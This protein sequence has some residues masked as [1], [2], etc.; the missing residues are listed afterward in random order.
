MV[1]MLIRRVALSRLLILFVALA[2]AVASAQ[3]PQGR[4]AAPPAELFDVLEQ[5]ILD[6]Q[7]AQAAMRAR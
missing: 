4:A 7:A 5:S 2:Q 6:L 1:G 3:R